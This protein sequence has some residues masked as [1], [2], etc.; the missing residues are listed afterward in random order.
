M[1]VMKETHAYLESIEDTLTVACDI[2]VSLCDLKRTCMP[3][4][5]TYYK[6]LK[7]WHTEMRLKTLK[8]PNFQA[9]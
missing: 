3:L 1:K 4:T 8:S 5:I 2:N 9:L 6:S 7:L